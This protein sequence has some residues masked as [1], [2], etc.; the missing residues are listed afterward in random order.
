M[1]VPP[2]AMILLADVLTLESMT[3]PLIEYCIHTHIIVVDS[4]M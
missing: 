2:P 4:Q 3:L 1:M